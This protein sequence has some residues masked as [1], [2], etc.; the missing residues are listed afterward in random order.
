MNE[1]DDNNNKTQTLFTQ[2]LGIEFDFSTENVLHSIWLWSRAHHTSHIHKRKYVN[3]FSTAL[4]FD[5]QQTF[6]EFANHFKEIS[7]IIQE[8][9]YAGEKE[10]EF[11]LWKNE[12]EF[13]R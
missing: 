9:M 5:N 12:A 11:K 10:S 4:P 13:S 3:F 1:T 6:I 7:N 2:I 8:I